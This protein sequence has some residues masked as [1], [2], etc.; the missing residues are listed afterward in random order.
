V[1]LG[2]REGCEG[3]FGYFGGERRGSGGTVGAPEKLIEVWMVVDISLVY[4]GVKE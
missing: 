2:G 3:L 4:S 1:V